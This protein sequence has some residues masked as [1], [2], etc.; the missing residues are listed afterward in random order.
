MSERK[1][2]NKVVIDI[3]TG[4]TLY[5]DSYLYKGPLALCDG[6]DPSPPTGD[7][8]T[9]PAAP[10]NLDPTPPPPVEPPPEPAPK[11]FKYKDQEEAENA[12]KGLERKLGHQGTKIGTLEQ[13]IAR[14]T[15]QSPVAAAPATP[16]ASED[17]PPVKPKPEDFDT[18]G[19]RAYDAYTEA[20]EKYLEDLMEYKARKIVSQ[21]DQER[22]TRSEAQKQQ[23]TV[24]QIAQTFEERMQKAGEEDPE[25]ADIRN[26]K[27]IPI[28][29]PMAACIMQSEIPDKLLRYFH[30]HREEAKKIFEMFPP[31]AMREVA[32]IEITLSTPKEK[33]IKESS[34]PEPVVPVGGN[35]G[36]NAL[37]PLDDKAP[38]E[39]FMAARNKA[40]KERLRAS[41]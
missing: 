39:S 26:D 16:P 18:Y 24:Q 12:Y 25:I 36:M 1:I 33:P 3:M 35:K 41:G 28:S 11:K 4:D 27:T 29:N 17:K 15:N 20:H 8:P 6:A 32:R 22:E 31:A 23:Q 37:A 38:I 10:D 14:L 40:V 34:A 9:D 2:Y 7:V 21:R 13:V 19:D 30:E 5:E